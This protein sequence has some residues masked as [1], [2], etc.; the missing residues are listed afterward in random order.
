MLK[1]LTIKNYALIDQLSVDFEP[2]FSTITGETGAGKSIILGGLSLVLGA[3]S[4]QSHILNKNHKCIIEAHFMIEGLSLHSFFESN[5][6]D[7]EDQTIIRR[8]ILTSGKSR[9]FV[10]DT[11]VSLQ[12][13]S[14]LSDHLIDI[15]T[16]H[17]TRSLLEQS[18][19]LEV[20]DQV[21]GNAPNLSEYIQQLMVYKSSKQ[22]LNDL[23]QS[24]EQDAVDRDY[25]SFL[26]DELT[27]ANL[28]VGMLEHLE[29]EFE[30]LQ[31]VDQIE[32]ALA[33]AKQ[34]LS[35]DDVGITE[36]LRQIKLCLNPIATMSP[37]YQ[38]LLERIS[39]AL[40][41]LDDVL[42]D[43]DEHLS[44]VESNPERLD[45]V[46]TQIHN[47]QL[48]LTKHKVKTVE[49]LIAIAEKLDRDLQRID[50]IDQ[51][52]LDQKNLV[53]DHKKQLLNISN[54]LHKKRKLAIPQTVKFL[55]SNLKALGM[56]DARFDLK[57]SSSEEFLSS[58]CDTVVWSFCS[59]KGGSF[60]SL[61]KSAS[62]GELSRIMLVVKAMLSQHQ[63]LPALIFDEIDT[64]VSGEIASKMG[65]IMA[66]MGR[67]MQVIAIT[68]LPQIAAQG[69]NHFKVFKSSD[70]DKTV[71][72][73]R[74]LSKDQRIEEIAAM[75][76]GSSLT[77]AAIANAKELLN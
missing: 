67:N 65:G 59:T 22:K 46:N 45:T 74:S 11:P 7:Y 20:L 77:K 68:H 4:D 18:Y 30:I 47:L 10:N 1:R 75:V 32:H 44:S 16:Q 26:L 48:L 56:P 6:L 13:L 25:K 15:H 60:Q 51:S 23:I 41:E 8:E 40:I 61:K 70:A 3:R 37:K 72:L 5:D 27:A 34:T 33:L 24:Q 42:S 28:K 52:I 63:N 71:V 14:Q 62:G 58:G 17:Q 2:G 9:A 21:A 29:E 38:N 35:A 64:G 39:S 36:M 73:I 31:N 43:V 76:S 49:D 66:Q 69:K 50:N 57:L 19:Q 55:E 53:A 54:E 12:L